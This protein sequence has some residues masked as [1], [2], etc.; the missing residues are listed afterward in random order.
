MPR[1]AVK[2][3]VNDDHK[4]SLEGQPYFAEMLAV[5]IGCGGTH[6]RFLRCCASLGS[7]PWLWQS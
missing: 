2:R 6:C 3:L 7:N 5:S 4:S 1:G